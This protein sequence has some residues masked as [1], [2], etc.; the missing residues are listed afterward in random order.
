M[1]EGSAM[2][3]IIVVGIDGS[4]DG[5]RALAWALDEAR[6]RGA[7]LEVIHA[8]ELTASDT[9]S[10]DPAGNARSVLSHSLSDI[11]TE[12]VEVHPRLVEGRP[13]PSL[14]QAAAEADLLVVGSRGRSGIAA[15][16]LGSVSSACVHF[17]SCPVVVV[18]PVRRSSMVGARNGQ[19]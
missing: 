10:P 11:D 2:A 6:Q 16:I 4:D 9:M 12:G 19:P 8:W 5:Q 15:V 17:A 3:E 1:S 13:V 7:V 18:P 14:V